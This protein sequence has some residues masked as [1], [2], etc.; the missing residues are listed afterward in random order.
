MD[1]VSYSAIGGNPVAEDVAKL[2]EGVHIVVCTPGR[3]AEL[4]KAGA[5]KQE[6]L[7]IVCVDRPSTTLIGG[8]KD[9][10]Y[11]I[12]QTLPGAQVVLL[13]ATVDDA[14]REVSARFQHDPI[15]VVVNRNQEPSF[16]GIQQ[17]FVSVKDEK[18]KLET[19]TDLARSG[20]TQVAIFCNTRK[21]VDELAEELLAW[22]I[23]VFGSSWAIF[24]MKRECG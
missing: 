19:L 7:K 18:G 5:L 4:I 13:S 9:Q 17:L 21:S 10:L 23:P 12:L 20:D 2:R 15:H 6:H 14:V 16:L 1:I 22:K 11:A 24:L 8:F 3:V